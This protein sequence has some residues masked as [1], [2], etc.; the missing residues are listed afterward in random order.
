MLY[1]TEH[2]LLFFLIRKHRYLCVLIK[3]KEEV[4]YLYNSSVLLSV[5]CLSCK[6]KHYQAFNQRT[7]YK[8][9][10][11]QQIPVQCLWIADF[12]EV[13]IQRTKKEHDGQNRGDPQRHSVANIVFFHPEH[14]PA[15]YN[16][17]DVWEVDLN[18]KVP[19]ASVKVEGGSEN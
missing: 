3:Q 4:K 16:H 15:Q 18:E 10:R 11:N 13:T 19:D 12:R 9:K 1:G 5:C 6:E 17:K 2:C 7:E 14:D 8:A